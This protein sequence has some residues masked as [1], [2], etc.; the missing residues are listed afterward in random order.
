MFLK[1]IKD[2]VETTFEV[3]KVKSWKSGSG[4]ED[5]TE[6]ILCIDYTPYSMESS[7]IDFRLNIEGDAQVYLQNNSGKT[8]ERIL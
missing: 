6:E 3:S 2:N 7:G 8:I 4:V 5:S 1:V